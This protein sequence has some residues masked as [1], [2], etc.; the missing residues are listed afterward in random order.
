MFTINQKL[1]DDIKTE[2]HKFLTHHIVNSNSDLFSFYVAGF[3]AGYMKRIED[4][5]NNSPI[6]E[7]EWD[8]SKLDKQSGA[9]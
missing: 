1:E 5:T 7:D 2:F 9:Q 3:K 4:T 8:L 6:K